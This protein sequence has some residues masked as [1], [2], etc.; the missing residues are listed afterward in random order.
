MGIVGQIDGSEV[1]WSSGAWWLVGGQF[2]FLLL[3]LI[4]YFYQGRQMRKADL[5]ES[6]P[7]ERD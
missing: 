4:I 6:E 2:L 7:T 1:F 3:V 5:N